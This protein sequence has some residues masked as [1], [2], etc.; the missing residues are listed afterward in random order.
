MIKCIK[1]NLPL[2]QQG[3]H[4]PTPMDTNSLAVEML[5]VPRSIINDTL[6][7]LF[8]EVLLALKKSTRL[9]NI[10]IYR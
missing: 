1:S 3:K 2:G 9:L 6:I 7:L 10:D 8:S 5:A 4:S